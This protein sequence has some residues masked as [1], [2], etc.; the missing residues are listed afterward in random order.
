VP[1]YLQGKTVKRKSSRIGRTFEMS[2]TTYQ[3]TWHNTPEDWAL[4][5]RHSEHLI[6]CV[7]ELSFRS[8][9]SEYCVAVS[10]A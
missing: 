1:F 7:H 2:V 3:T 4:R 6:Y 8:A 5:Q 9:V 10:E